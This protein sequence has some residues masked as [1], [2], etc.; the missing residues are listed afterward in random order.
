MPQQSMK[1]QPLADEHREAWVADLDELAQA[2]R[3]VFASVR[4]LRGRDTHLGGT[5]LSHAQVELLVELYQRG[6]LS[7]GELATAAQLTPASVTQMLEP[8]AESGYVERTRDERDR[9]VVRSRLT[10]RGKREIEAKRKEKQTL[11]EHAL[12]DVDPGEMRAATRVL[13]R[14]GA[15]FD[16]V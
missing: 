9:R 8:L 2:F 10:A 13:R 16:E 1:A 15:M 6:E 14:V 5:A 12:A 4:R 11:W 7:A 3:D